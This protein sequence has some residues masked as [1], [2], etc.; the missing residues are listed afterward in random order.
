MTKATKIPSFVLAL[1]AACIAGSAWP[2]DFAFDAYAPSQIAELNRRLPHD[3]AMLVS[4][5][6]ASP[7][8]KVRVVYTKTTRPI[9][10]DVAM[11]LDSWVKALGVSPEVRKIFV[12]EVQVMEGDARFWLPI[13]EPVLKWL[14]KEPNP[15]GPADFYIVR[16][17]SVRSGPVYAV[18]EYEIR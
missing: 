17:G 8:Y 1:A 13:Q 12:N 10:P 9:S 6:A 14:L 16:L 2:A 11:M 4:V 3:P 7:R 5:D 15:S 18:N